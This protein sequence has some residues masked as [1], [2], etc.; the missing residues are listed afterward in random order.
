MATL[1]E[2]DKLTKDYADARAKLNDTVLVLHDKTEALRRQYLPGIKKQV[3]I[4]KQRKSRLTAAIEDSPG[5]FGRPRTVIYYGI[6]IGLKKAKGL[7]KWASEETVIKLIRKHL[8]DQAD[9]LIKTTEKVLKK[10]LQ[11]LPGA[12]LKKIGVTIQDTEDAPV[13]EPVDSEVDKLVKALL[14]EEIEK[15]EGEA[16]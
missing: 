5:L 10:P 8:P 4:A 12:D 11:Q 1:E 2:L 6:K 13:I 7:V 3:A 9:L 16:A 15:E 14:D